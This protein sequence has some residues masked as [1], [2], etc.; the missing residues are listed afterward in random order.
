MLNDVQALAQR[1]RHFQRVLPLTS[2]LFLTYRCNSH[3]RT[4]TFWKRPHREEEK[5][6]IGFQEWRI[7]IDKLAAA[8]VRA[9][10]VFGGNVLLRKDLLLSV[11]RYLKEKEFEIHLP[12][13]QI[14]LDDEI[15]RSIV[16]Y[17]DYVYISTDGVGEHQ[18]AIRGLKG[19]SQRAEAAVTKLLRL[20]RGCKTPK[21]ICNTTVSRYNADLLDDLAEYA[22]RMGFDEIH[23]DY[24]GEISKE[25]LEHSVI[26]GLLPTPYFLKEGESILVD[27]AGAKRLKQ[28]LR[29]IRKKHAH[30]DIDIVTVN[31]DVL[32]EENLYEGTIPHGKCYVD[33]LEV[34]VDP[35]G[36]LIPCAFINNYING[37]LLNDA[38]ED[39]WNNERYQRFRRQQN[40]GAIA[41]C[42]H[43]ILGVQRNP[44]LLTSLKRIYLSRLAPALYG[45][46]G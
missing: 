5:R 15:A 17:V 42:K 36:N 28:S 34:T 12:T 43:C 33:R 24:A 37:N 40:R 13:N 23:F 4:C 35:A 25:H 2:L 18:D 11:L 41:M 30:S 9:T 19:S 38:F 16:T 20:R 8:G 46:R 45:R 3:C 32:T 39:V 14:G 29:R 7:I 6:E 1:Q 31:I 21:I 44:G 10:E 22:L 26:D 27:R